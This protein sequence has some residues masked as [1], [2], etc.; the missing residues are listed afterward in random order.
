MTTVKNHIEQMLTEWPSS[1]FPST[2]PSRCAEEDWA[3]K[4]SDTR[5]G[6]CLGTAFVSVFVGIFHVFTRF[7]LSHQGQHYP[8][9]CGQF[10]WSPAK[11]QPRISAY[12]SR[13]HV[14][15]HDVGID[16][17]WSGRQLDR[18]LAAKSATEI[19]QR[20]LLGFSLVF[21]GG[22]LHKLKLSV[23]GRP[24]QKWFRS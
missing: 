24:D 23:L 17:G 20:S 3:W 2:Q 13:L 16:F 18:D 9:P 8:S 7:R 19:C 22:L 11:A 5:S 12:N 15:K 1:A 10:A 4:C 6:T 21:G 14:G